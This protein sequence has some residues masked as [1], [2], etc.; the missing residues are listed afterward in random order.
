MTRAQI[1]AARERVAGVLEELV[2]R[3]WGS[4]T[5]P[6]RDALCSRLVTAVLGHP[7][8]RAP[9]TKRRPPWPKRAKR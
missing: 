1:E 8:G 7:D 5:P 2:P 3:G 4:W 9:S 6:L